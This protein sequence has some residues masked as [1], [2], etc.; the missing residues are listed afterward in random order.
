MLLWKKE[1]HTD[2]RICLITDYQ[3]LKII[4]FNL[5]INKI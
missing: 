4:K 1:C 3:L 5:N 2:G